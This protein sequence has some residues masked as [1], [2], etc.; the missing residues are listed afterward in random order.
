MC[1]SYAS[2]THK[3]AAHTTHQL[4]LPLHTGRYLPAWASAHTAHTLVHASHSHTQPHKRTQAETPSHLLPHAHD[5]MQMQ[6]THM[7]S[8]MHTSAHTRALPYVHNHTNTHIHSLMRTIA[9]TH[10]LMHAHNRTCQARHLCSPDGRRSC[11]PCGQHHAHA[12][13]TCRAD[14]LGRR[15]MAAAGAHMCTPRAVM[16]VWLALA[17]TNLKNPVELVGWSVELGTASAGEHRLDAS[18]GST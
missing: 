1:I 10:A 3:Q 13:R 15:R 18:W 16:H 4:T 5:C 12:C 2:S 9:H 11:L 6:R 8:R 17:H 7:N 14:G